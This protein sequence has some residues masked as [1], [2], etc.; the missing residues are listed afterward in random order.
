MNLSFIKTS[1]TENMTILV[2]TPLPRNQYKMVATKLMEYG[3]VYAEQVGFM[4]TPTSPAAQTRLQM[5]GGEF[6]GNA[7]LS[8]AAIQVWKRPYTQGAK[9]DVLLESS[10]AEK[11]VVCSVE[12]IAQH[13]F[14]VSLAMPLPQGIEEISLSLDGHTLSPTAVHFGGITHLILPTEGLF[15]SPE[16]LAPKMVSQWAPL[17]QSDAL[18]LMFFDEKTHALT[19]FVYVK[20]VQSSVWERGCG[21]GS[22]AVGSYL[23]YQKKGEITASLAQKGGIITVCANWIDN[24]ISALSIT[25]GVDIVAS[26]TAYLPD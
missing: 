8:A 3:H 24:K 23:A 7:T 21:S 16:I 25:G 18:G 10:G 14:L 17:F 12:T 15:E 6:C 5:M 9:E 2:E 13:R 1:P 19:P 20:S 22:A 11:P 26:G 4:E